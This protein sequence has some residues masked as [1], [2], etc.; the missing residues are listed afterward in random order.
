MAMDE[1]LQTK[2]RLNLEEGRKVVLI[3]GGADGIPRGARILRDLS[4]LAD[5]HLIIVCGKNTVLYQQAMS[6][7]S[8]R[9]HKHTTVYGYVDFIHDLITVSDLVISKCGASTF[10]EILLL[11]KIPIVTDYIWEQEKGNVEFLQKH[12]FG[13]FEPDLGKLPGLVNTLLND[14]KLHSSLTSN[15]RNAGLRNGAEEIAHWLVGR[16]EGG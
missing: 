13:Y 1:I 14:E 11:G 3:F 10:K 6:I 5:A 7:K 15:I 2:K 12:K 4:V 9:G 16:K 8:S